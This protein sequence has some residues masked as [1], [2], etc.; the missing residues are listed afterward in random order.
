M[1]LAIRE[2]RPHARFVAPLWDASCCTLGDLY[3]GDKTLA[4]ITNSPHARVI[5]QTYVRARRNIARAGL[6]RA[7]KSYHSD[8]ETLRS[9]CGPR[10]RKNVVDTR[11]IS[12]FAPSLSFAREGLELSRD[13]H[14]VSC[15]P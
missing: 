1:A 11:L 2:A 3:S 7:T 6:E 5:I 4:I 14:G 8:S 15:D 12:R 13:T 10:E 9:K